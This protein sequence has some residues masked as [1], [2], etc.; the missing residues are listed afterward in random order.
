MFT[1]TLLLGGGYLVGQLNK[2]GQLTGMDI[3][4]IYPD[5]DTGITGRDTAVGGY[6]NTMKTTFNLIDI[7]IIAYHCISFIYPDLNTSITGK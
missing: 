1:F 3:S 5:L 6:I 2:A 7:D 4:F